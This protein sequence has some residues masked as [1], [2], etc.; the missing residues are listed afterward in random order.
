MAEGISIEAWALV[1]YAAA[2]A[3]L[4]LTPGPVIVALVARAV[5]GGVRAAV[6]LSFG[7]VVGDMLWPLAA[8]FGVGVLVS[9]YADFLILLR[10][11]GAALLMWMGWGLIRGASAAISEDASL[12]RPGDLQ[13]FLAGLGVI[14]GNPKAILFYLGV[15]PNFFDVTTL[16]G[17]DVALICG[18]SGLVPFLGNLI[19]AGLF[20][21]TRSFLTSPTAVR[22]V[23]FG[24]GLA[25]VFVGIAILVF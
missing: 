3:I 8:I 6:P 12:A 17:W 22:R 15:L 18:V 13:G 16:S 10:L 24:A 20:S 19:W 4:V 14:I 5:T 9:L 7:V 2:L 23:N 1:Q 21:V 11:F 25:L